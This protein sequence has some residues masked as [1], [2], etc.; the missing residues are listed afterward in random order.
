MSN[1]R[2]GS[3]RLD[4]PNSGDFS[5]AR[6]P[7]SPTDEMMSP[8]TKQIRLKKVGSF[9]DGKKREKKNV[10]C[11]LKKSIQRT[12]FPC[13]QIPFILGT[14]SANRKEVIESIGWSFEQMSPDIDG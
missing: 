9:L 14:S 10:D 4:R 2:T 7:S 5:I 11:D 13:G 6:T 3:G 1:S 8:I 12:P